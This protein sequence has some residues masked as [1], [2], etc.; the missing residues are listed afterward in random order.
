MGDAG[1]LYGSVE[2]AAALIAESTGWSRSRWRETE[3]RAVERE[4]A[5]LVLRPLLEEWQRL[6]H[7][8]TD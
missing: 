6:A 2:E 3:M 1:A 7:G 8:S 5:S 4:G